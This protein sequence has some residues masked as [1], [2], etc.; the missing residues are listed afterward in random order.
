MADAKAILAKVK[1]KVKKKKA[2]VKKLDIEPTGTKSK[3]LDSKLAA[4]L[5][6]EFGSDFSKVKIHTGGN[7]AEIAKKLGAK[8][9]TCGYDVHFAKAGDAGNLQL[10]AHELTHV[11]Q[12]QGGKIKPAMKGKA[13]TSK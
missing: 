2:K 4:A 12:Q 9:F 8:A 6:E 11:V 5:K 7:T 1:E 3:K 10:I 13:L